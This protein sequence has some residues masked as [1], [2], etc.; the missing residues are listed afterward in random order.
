MNTY[1]PEFSIVVPIYNEV[2]NISDLYERLTP[3]MKELCDR[4]GLSLDSYEIIMVDDGSK[5][6]SWQIIRGLHEKDA[7]VKAISFSR[8]FGHH[9]ALTAGLDYAKGRVII[10]M[11]GDLQD[12]PEE[13]PKLYDKFKEGYDL[14]YGIRRQRQDPFL[15]KM[16]SYFFWQI[17]RKFSGV[18][19]P[20]GQTMLRILSRRLVDVLKDM[21]EQARFI[22]G[23]MAWAGFNSTTVEIAHNP[24]LKGKSKYNVPRMFKLA[25]HAITAFSTIP[26]R[27]ATYVGL[28]SSLI[29]LIVGL[30][31]IF[32]KILYGIPV[33]G[34]ASIIVSIFFVGGL[35]LLI[36]GIFGEY[37]GR[38]YQAVQQ[39]PL[40][41]IKE[42]IF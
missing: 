40:Y 17:L 24:R 29:S 8:N 25:F 35:Q 3:V 34:Y 14:V 23:M 39:R 4:E 7:K 22:H 20:A 12:P 33:L 13:I 2:E 1:Q 10:L 18:D 36:I 6:G 11:D 38:T 41:V 5:D 28:L 37:L 42:Q 21:R 27:I 9:M 32:R 26:L 30:Y 16:T 19:I 31:F 15:K